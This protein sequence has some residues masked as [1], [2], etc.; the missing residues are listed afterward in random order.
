MTKNIIHLFAFL[1]LVHSFYNGCAQDIHFSQFSA[2]PLLLNPAAAGNMKG[3]IRA[4]TNYRNQW[5]SV[6]NSYQTYS[7]AADMN[8]K[9]L[10]GSKKGFPGLGLSL[11]RDQAGDLKYARTQAELSLAYHVYLNSRNILSGGVQAGMA[12]RSFDRSAMM[13]DSQFDGTAYNPDLPGETSVIPSKAFVD[14]GIGMHWVY[15]TGDKNMVSNDGINL[16]AGFSLLHLAGTNQSMYDIHDVKSRENIKITGYSVASLGVPQSNIA[17]Q[18]AIMYSRQNSVFEMTGG[19]VMRYRLVEASKYTGFI[20]ESALS[21]GAYCRWNDAVIPM[22]K[23]EYS[24][25]AAGVS[26]D[27]NISSLHTATNFRGGFEIFIQY[28]TPNPFASQRTSAKF[29]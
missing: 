18:P 25:W 27:I 4:V 22:I 29:I 26:Y 21:L 3:N 5:L 28:I 17:V 9:S 6:A 8:L 23:F 12:Q 7:L 11:F 2:S 20:K 10:Y 16:T 13:W 1:V 15:F 14:V 24:N 19:I